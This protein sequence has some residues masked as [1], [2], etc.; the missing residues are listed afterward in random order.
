MTVLLYT[1]GTIVAFN[2]LVRI[3]TVLS[4]YHLSFSLVCLPSSYLTCSAVQV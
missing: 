3:H 4:I 1:F 2:P